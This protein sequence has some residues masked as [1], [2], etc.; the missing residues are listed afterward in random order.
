MEE[1]S[2]NTGDT[3]ALEETRET[4]QDPLLKQEENQ[5]NSAL[6]TSQ[7]YYT[8]KSAEDWRFRI[9]WIPITQKNRPSDYMAAFMNF[10]IVY[11]LLMIFGG[12]FVY[13][14][15]QPFKEGNDV[16]IPF[17][18]LMYG[19]IFGTSA[20]D[21]KKIIQEK[22]VAKMNKVRKMVIYCQIEAVLNLI[23]YALL[24]CYYVP[25]VIYGS[26]VYKNSNAVFKFFA[27]DRPRA[28]VFAGIYGLLT[29]IFLC[30]ATQYRKFNRGY[31]K[32]VNSHTN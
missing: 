4:S 30:K 29:L 31:T 23:I 10:T 25:L 19:Y 11:S 8:N 16:P 2:L 32:I 17:A 6:E 12:L 20:K 21:A 5:D 27:V 7:I 24:L 1:V 18:P 15:S 13:F 3:S 28:S 14:S 9:L 26:D 22:F